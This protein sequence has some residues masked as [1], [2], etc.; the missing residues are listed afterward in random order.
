MDSSAPWRFDSITLA[1]A[2]WCERIGGEGLAVDRGAEVQ[3]IRAGPTD[4]ERRFNQAV[5]HSRCLFDPP[6]EQR[7]LRQPRIYGAI[8]PRDEAVHRHVFIELIERV[9]EVVNGSRLTRSLPRS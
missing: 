9:A 3:R 2:A 6:D 4:D 1:V 8:W 5:F 7:G